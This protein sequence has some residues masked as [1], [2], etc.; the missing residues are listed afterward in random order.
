M[1]VNKVILY[2][3]YINIAYNISDNSDNNL[4][5][6]NVENYSDIENKLNTKEEQSNLGLLS[7]G[8]GDRT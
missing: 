8:A 7:L 6:E 5:L 2:D 1:F 4:K 3:D